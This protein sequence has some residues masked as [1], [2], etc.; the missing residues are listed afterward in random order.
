MADL[1]KHYR[2]LVGI[3][4]SWAEKNLIGWDDDMHRNLLEQC[5][6][7]KIDG[8]ISASSLNV[9]QLSAVLNDYEKRGWPRNKKWQG[10]AQAQ[11]KTV[12]PQIAH[13]VKMWGKLGQ[14]GKVNNTSRAALLNFCARQTAKHVPDLD[15]LST[16]EAQAI[17]EALKSWLA[18]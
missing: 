5:G 8:R 14:A 1:N 13:I 3:A 15:S 11:A 16:E 18:R 9:P 2:Q 17:I 12:T 6:A 7:I 10:N 4:K